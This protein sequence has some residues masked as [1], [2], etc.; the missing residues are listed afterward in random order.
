MT[1]GKANPGLWT[2]SPVP[3]TLPLLAVSLCYTEGVVETN[4]QKW[5]TAIIIGQQ[6]IPKNV[7]HFSRP[8]YKLGSPSFNFHI[9]TVPV[10]LYQLQNVH[11][12]SAWPI[13]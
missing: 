6:W 8:L 10:P 4:Y 9:R 2:G 13:T 3:L 11:P 12:H 1:N 7:G 5:K